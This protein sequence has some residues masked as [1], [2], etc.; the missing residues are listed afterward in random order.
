M[1]TRLANLTP[2]RLSLPKFKGRERGSAVVMFLALLATMLVLVTANGKTLFLLKKELRHIEQRQI[3]RL[4]PS[5]TNAIATVASPSR[6]VQ[7][8]L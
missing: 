7:P 5:K 1:K 2:D 6:P 8:A 4:G 3:Q